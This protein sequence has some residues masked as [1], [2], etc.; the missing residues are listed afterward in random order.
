MILAKY[1]FNQEVYGFHFLELQFF[2]DFIF[3]IL[4]GSP[5][6]WNKQKHASGTVLDFM[7]GLDAGSFEICNHSKDA[8]HF[9][10]II[11]LMDVKS[12]LSGIKWKDKGI[13]PITLRH[14][15]IYTPN[16][17]HLQT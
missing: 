17:S 11:T 13:T 14:I 16:C 12:A 10:G 9:S 15:T 2:H 6:N 4:W 7:R 5:E 8:A 1:G 3:R